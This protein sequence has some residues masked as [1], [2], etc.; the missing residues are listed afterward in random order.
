MIWD[1]CV[2]FF[3]QGS[4]RIGYT[5][6]PPGPGDVETF[7]YDYRYDDHGR[8]VKKTLPGKGEEYLVYNNL[9][10]IVATQDANQ[11]SKSPQ[12][13]S[14]T[15]YDG[16]GRVAQ[17]GL[18]LNI[19]D[20]SLETVRVAVQSQQAPATWE[21]RNAT[22]PAYT[23]R[24]WP[25]GDLT[26]TTEQFYDDYNV[27]GFPA[28]YNKS[29][30]HSKLTHGRAT[31]SRTRVLA[32]SDFLWRATYYNDRGDVVRNIGQH[33]LGGSTSSTKFDD[34]TNEY[35]FT[36]QLAKSIRRH[37][38]TH[39]TTPAVTIITEYEYDHR[40]RHTHTW[41]AVNNGERILLAKNT[42]NEIGQL[43]AKKLHTDGMEN[44]P[45]ELTLG[46]V[47]SV[48]TGQSSE[49]LASSSI[50]LTP[51]FHAAMGSTFRAAIGG[52]SAQEILYSYN[53]RGWTTSINNPSSVTDKQ[54]FG[55]TLNYANN[56]QAYNGNI[57][58]VQWN[59]KVSSSQTQTPLQTYTYT[60]DQ[61]NR[62]KKAVYTASGKNNYFNEELSYDVMGNID[63]LRRS[64]GATSWYNH[65][66][67]QYEGNRWISLADA[68][69][70]N[71]GNSFTY[72]YNGNAKTNTRLGITNIEYNYLNLPKKFVKGSQN[73]IYTY[74]ATGKK[75]RKELG[76]AVTDYVDG[77]Q[78]RNGAI[79][80]IQTE[81]GRILPTGSSFIYEYF[82]KDHLGNTRAIIDHT[83]AI[84]QIQNYYA[85]G[86]EMNTGGGLNSASNHYKYNGKE[87]QTEM[88][89]DQLDY[90]ARFYDAEIGRWNVPDPLAEKYTNL[91]PY[92]YAV[93]NPIK[94][95]DPDGRSVELTGEAAQ[96]AFTEFLRAN[97]ELKEKRGDED[98]PTNFIN[99]KGQVI[100][101][102][103]D[104]SNDTYVINEGNTQKF[105]NS[106][107]AWSETGRDK[108]KTVNDFLG[109][110]FGV[111]LGKYK[112]SFMHYP[113]E[114]EEYDMSFETGYKNGYEKGILNIN[115][116]LFNT[117]GTDERTKRSGYNIGL[118]LGRRHNKDGWMNMFNPTLKSSP[119]LYIIINNQLR[120][121]EK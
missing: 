1:S 16:L 54:L 85:F 55:M 43:Y 105:L 64:N 48:G 9:N 68:G 102:T 115:S 58:S 31:V 82:L 28:A 121:N 81:E 25:T 109:K 62:L 93:N 40:E 13:W 79:E 66:K 116:I 23:N 61:L 97:P 87:K 45:E 36:G 108:D 3:H 94:F 120:K 117:G 8:L 33:Y 67:C 73:L 70:V 29:D 114:I 12:E 106:I 111:S 24:S 101:R 19:G 38:T 83:G 44:L 49:M 4:I 99:E 50:T 51:G 91:S 41:K 46:A 7:G 63:T 89:L 52:E 110:I 90:G 88:G 22:G 18:W 84:K 32:T 69:T 59:T 21:E 17:T 96:M 65:F 71:W 77:I 98:P 57:G 26:V 95:I 35:T 37:H 100:L 80:F 42:Y 14:V 107:A 86:M 118:H 60:Y 104:G 39:A 6:P 113:T 27:S 11:R 20:L 30:S 5:P 47:E 112:N 72:D 10:Q 103:E 78:Y 76:S 92:N 56:P 15:K 75:L 34:T 53:E 119:A 2:L 74:D